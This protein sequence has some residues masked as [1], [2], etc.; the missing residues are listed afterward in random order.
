MC[1]EDDFSIGGVLV[2]K[3]GFSAFI[4]VH[5]SNLIDENRF[6][7]QNKCMD[8]LTD[9][10]QTAGLRKRI[11]NQHQVPAHWS[12]DFPCDKSMG[13]HVVL[14]GEVLASGDELEDSRLQAGDMVFM[15][16]GKYHRLRAET[17][18]LVVS[19][20]YQLW[21]A[22][23]HPL[24]DA[25]PP[26]WVVRGQQ[27][28]YG[29]GLMQVLG[30][31][32]H[33]HQQTEA[34]GAASVSSALLD[35]LFYYILREGLQSTG[36]WHWTTQDVEITRALQYMH[37]APAENWSLERLAQKVGLS[38]SGFALRFKQTLGDSPAH[39]LTTLRMSKAMQMLS[40]T[41]WTLEQ[42]ATQ[43][44]YKDAFGFS[45]AFKKVVG[46]S[47]AAFRRRNQAEAH[48]SWRFGP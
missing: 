45:K 17:P 14:Q 7:C 27:Q 28:T 31:M 19:G 42:I 22:P 5:S 23:V 30:L 16:R 43:V 47:P 1:F 12:M 39:Y 35:I 32:A 40:E 26:W 38:R 29:T 21:H 20:A 3:N 8:I 25:L 15:A 34:F 48:L 11:L 10:L 24:F 6:L 36:Q 13:F 18:A 33:E 44:G 4:Y 46:E 2:F 37:Q 9:I 41:Q